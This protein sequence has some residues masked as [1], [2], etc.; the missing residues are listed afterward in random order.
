MLNNIFNLGLKREL[1]TIEFL[2]YNYEVKSFLILIIV[3]F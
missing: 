2:F 1:Y 3:M